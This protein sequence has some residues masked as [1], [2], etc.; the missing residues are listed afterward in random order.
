MAAVLSLL[1]VSCRDTPPV[2]MQKREKL[3][4]KDFTEGKYMEAIE[5]YKS[6]YVD[7]DGPRPTMPKRDILYRIAECYRGLNAYKQEIQWYTKV[8]KGD[9]ADSAKARQ[10]IYEAQQ[11]IKADSLKDKGSPKDSVK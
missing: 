9:F 8:I 4:D 6:M 1:A 2:E 7:M 5:L 10:Y 3:A 11:H